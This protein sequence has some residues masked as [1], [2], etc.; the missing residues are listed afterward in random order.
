MR[1]AA[2]AVLSLALLAPPAFAQDTEEG[3]SLMEEGAR[4]LLRGMI[5][6]ID[7]AIGDFTA[8]AE[9]AGPRLRQFAME[10]GPAL[11]RI[12]RVIDDLDNYAAPEILPNGDIIIRR[13]PDA[14]PFEP[15][16]IDI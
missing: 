5:A 14:P 13:L 2:A 9:E 1:N 7:P 6:E 16:E 8:F 11:Q 15:G 4:L 10:M 12:L 3:L